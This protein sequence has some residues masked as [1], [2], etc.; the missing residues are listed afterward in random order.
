MVV[1][2]GGAFSCERGTPVQDRLCSSNPETKTVTS[3]SLL[4]EPCEQFM[5]RT[6]RTGEPP[7]LRGFEL[8][9]RSFPLRASHF[10]SPAL[11][12]F[13]ALVNVASLT[14]LLSAVD[15]ARI[16]VC[17]GRAVSSVP[18]SSKRAYK[19]RL[20]KITTRLDHIRHRN[21]ASGTNWSNRCTYRVLK[22]DTRRDYIR[23][24]HQS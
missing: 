21:T 17:Q 16:D 3:R 12:N 11:V 22:I 24:A 18:I 2:E 5:A 7:P 23:N 20:I 4:T 19:F 1:L 13:P 10:N 8:L 15:G 14:L 9:T 6:L